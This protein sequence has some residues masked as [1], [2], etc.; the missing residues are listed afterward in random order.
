MNTIG[1]MNIM[2]TQNTSANTFQPISRP[3]SILNARASRSNPPARSSPTTNAVNAAVT[4]S[5]VWFQS[6]VSLSDFRHTG[7]RNIPVMMIHARVAAALSQLMSNGQLQRNRRQIPSH[8]AL[9]ARAKS[10]LRGFLSPFLQSVTPSLTARFSS[11]DVIVQNI[12]KKESFPS[13]LS[14]E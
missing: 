10:G 5:M 4:Q 7:A 3:K 11:P 9:M 2:L 6:P 12:R 14:S 8:N 13:I 1:A